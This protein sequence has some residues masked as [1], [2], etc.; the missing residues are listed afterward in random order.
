MPELLRKKW[1][2]DA[3][4]K[5]EWGKTV[6]LVTDLRLA[7]ERKFVIFKPLGASGPN[8]FEDASILALVAQTAI[9]NDSEEIPPPA[10]TEPADGNPTWEDEPV[11]LADLDA[12]YEVVGNFPGRHPQT[13][14][15][16]TILLF[17]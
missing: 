5:E 1:Q 3:D 2:S 12:S 9:R 11:T 16:V 17:S 4:R 13:S 10:A 6:A 15:K 8:I 7:L 14:W